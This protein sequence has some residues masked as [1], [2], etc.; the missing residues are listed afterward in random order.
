MSSGGLAT[1]MFEFFLQFYFANNF[2]GTDFI[3]L[4]EANRKYNNNFI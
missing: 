2:L 4:I 1:F 3:D